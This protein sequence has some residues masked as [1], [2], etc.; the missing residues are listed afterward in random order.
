ML[1]EMDQIK[2]SE[3]IL[4]HALEIIYLLA[5]EV[6]VFQDLINSLMMREMNKDKMTERIL[7][8][9]LRI[10]CLLTGEEY[11]I[12][13]KNSPHSSIHQLTGEV[14]IKCGDVAV[15]FSMEE[16]EYI[17]GHKELYKD[18]MNEYQ[19]SLNIVRIPGNRSAGNVPSSFK[20]TEDSY[21]RSHQKTTEQKTYN[22]ISTEL[23]A[24]W[25]ISG[26]HQNA[27]PCINKP[28]QEINN[29]SDVHQ[30]DSVKKCYNDC[31]L[32]E[33]NKQI[34]HLKTK[35]YDEKCNF[36]DKSPEIVTHQTTDSRNKPLEHRFYG[37]LFSHIAN[38]RST[39]NTRE[40]T[41]SC[42]ACGKCFAQKLGL[43]RH[44]PIHT[45][46]KPFSCSECGTCFSRKSQLIIHQRKHK[47]ERPFSCS[48]CG[49]CFVQKSDLN[50][51]Q[52]IHT[53]E[54]PFSCSICG[55]SFSQKAILKRH[56]NIHTGEKR[57]LCSVCGKCFTQQSDLSRHQNIHKE[58]KSYFCTE[59]GKCF[60]RQ[61]N[62]IEHQKLH[63]GERIFSCTKCGKCFTRQTN[64]IRHL[65]IHN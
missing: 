4:T 33:H 23:S 1:T 9:V 53:G 43:T 16:W 52:N 50:R 22:N 47:G 44:W 59:C 3:L 38:Q 26:K 19:Q 42:S 55:K 15:Y 6:S 56:Q 63:K 40:K 5:G 25:N 48:E 60:T 46:D 61:T 54:K 21:V 64:L 27:V 45:G 8:R 36:L 35:K 18:V 13:K 39:G 57:F 10:I 32:Q 58:E 29:I 30:K 65:R 2:M 17:E 11:T 20:Q 31:A 7:V 28:S 49:K 34:I 12:V 62:L 24:C 41:F 37:K 14:P 51:H